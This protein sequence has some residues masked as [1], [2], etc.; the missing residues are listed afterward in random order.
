MRFGESEIKTN[1]AIKFTISTTIK[2]TTSISRT[3]KEISATSNQ[4]EPWH[5]QHE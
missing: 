1:N 5:H 2:L 4:Q 3:I